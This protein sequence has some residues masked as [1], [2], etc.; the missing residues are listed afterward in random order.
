MTWI[1]LQGSLKAPVTHI[2]NMYRT[3]KKIRGKGK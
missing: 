1:K 2:Q 3:H